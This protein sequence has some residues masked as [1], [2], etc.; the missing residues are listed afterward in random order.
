MT[1]DKNKRWWIINNNDDN[2]D[3][4]N[5]YNNYNEKRSTRRSVPRGAG[6]AGA[7]RTEA[8]PVKPP[9]LTPKP[10][11]LNPG[12]PKNPTPEPQNKQ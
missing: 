8:P 7:P 4:D 2:D 11:P 1:N 3:N 9:N 6:D 5:N 12:T 10:Q